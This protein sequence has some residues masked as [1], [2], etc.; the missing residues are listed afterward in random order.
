MDCITILMGKKLTEAVDL[1][2]DSNRAFRWLKS[3][4]IVKLP[5]CTMP[6]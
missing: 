3:L 5:H 6:V 4:Q 2:Y 1:I